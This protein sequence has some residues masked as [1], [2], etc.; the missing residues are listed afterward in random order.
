MV[1]K[2]VR[3]MLPHTKLGRKQFKIYMFMQVRTQARSTTT[4]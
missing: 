2:A 1:E 3:G 4:S